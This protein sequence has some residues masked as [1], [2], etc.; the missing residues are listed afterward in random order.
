MHSLI[1]DIRFGLRMLAK[2][3]GFTAIAVVTLAL[4]IGANTAVFSFVHGML[5]RPLGYPHEDR[6][7]C[8]TTA[9]P[10]EGWSGANASIP[11]YLDWRAQNTTF[12]DMGIYLT[13]SYNLTGG[14]QPERVSSVGASASLLAVLGVEAEIGRAFGPDEDQS[15]Q[16]R[17]AVLS[18]SFWQRRFGG[19]PG[20]VGTTVTLDDVPYT[21][22]GVLPAGLERAWGRFDV[23]TPFAI[24]DSGGDRGYGAY[25]IFGRLKPGVSVAEAQTELAG[26]AARLAESYPETNKGKTVE[27][28]P[29]RNAV[30]D[31]TARL[32]VAALAAA[33]GFVLLI[34]C[35]NVANL[36]LSRSM[37]RR[38]E[39][40]IRATLGARR[41]RLARQIVGESLILALAG[42]VL[43][44]VLAL[45]GVDL[46]VS[47]LPDIVPRREE[48][49]VNWQ[50]LAFTLVLALLTTLLFGL[51]PALQASRVSLHAALKGSA[52]S[53][54]KGRSRQVGR[55]TLAVVQMAMALALLICAGLMVKSFRWQQS[56]PLGFE[57][58]QALTMRLRLPSPRYASTAQQVSFIE[59]AVDRVGHAPGVTS[60]AAAHILPFDRSGNYPRVTAEDDAAEGVLRPSIVGLAV[61]TP[62]YF[63]TMGI[64]LLSG[65]DFAADDTSSGQPVVI[66][67][68]RYARRHWPAGAAVG[69][70]VKFGE[71]DAAGPW[72][73][74]VGVVGNVRRS[75]LDEGKLGYMYVPH[76]Q[77][78]GAYMAIV[79]RTPGDPLAATSAVQNAIWE[80]DP[81]QAVYE[82]RSLEDIVANDVRAWGVV[83]A[84]MSVFAAVALTLASAGVYG[85]M[86]YNVSRRTHEIGIR[87]AM[88]ARARDVLRLVL[89]KSL[90]LT[91]PGVVAGVGLAC[92]LGQALKSLM[93]KVAPF[94]PTTFVCVS[95][96]LVAVAMLAGYLPARRATRVDPLVA[97]HSE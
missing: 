12:E 29:I 63:E 38:R 84:M 87:L 57:A 85:V 91:L 90:L 79:A 78:G 3:P 82:V 32:A 22:L 49:A 88:G 71:P 6:L 89:R 94:D 76:G 77:V 14:E 36:L 13:S 60:A 52:E 35:V 56:D 39:F 73:T 2:A 75:A 10:V 37:T 28:K 40:A 70:R 51:P 41:W 16:E 69:K 18:Q 1:E 9:N 5:L 54:A 95:L 7:V 50:A 25:Q 55:D 27:V 62:R 11:D 31:D 58:R 65:R 47:R 93:Y 74:I 23:W 61:V 45:W 97:L 53:T 8:L 17:V 42:A 96:L 83:A 92:G 59:Q 4:G 44:V 15:G 68:E 19:E 67:N 48:I 21:I 24:Y 64:P 86:S 43:G 66:V 33:V 46:L 81:A 34:A 20:V 80:I 26:I 72:F 30:V